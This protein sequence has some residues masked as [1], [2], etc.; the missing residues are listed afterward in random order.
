M[1]IL[2]ATAFATRMQS[3]EKVTVLGE[4]PIRVR[5]SPMVIAG[6]GLFMQGPEDDQDDGAK[7]AELAQ[8][9]RDATRDFDEPLPQ[10]M[11]GG[12]FNKG[13]FLYTFNRAIDP[14][15][16]SGAFYPLRKIVEQMAI[17]LIFPLTILGIVSGALRGNPDRELVDGAKRLLVVMGLLWTYPLWDILVF[18]GIAGPVSLQLGS[19]V[20]RDVFLMR[21]AARRGIGRNPQAT[22]ESNRDTVRMFL[23]GRSIA[24]DSTVRASTSITGGV[25]DSV[26]QTMWESLVDFHQ[27]D[28]GCATRLGG[29]GLGGNPV[30]SS[31]AAPADTGRKPLG[32]ESYLRVQSSTSLLQPEFRVKLVEMQRILLSRGIR[33]RVVET[34]RPQKRQEWL[35]AEGKSKTLRSYHATGYAADM[36]LNNTYALK[37][38]HYYAEMKDVATSLNLKT[39]WAWDAGHVEMPGKPRGARPNQVLASQ[40]RPGTVVTTA[41]GTPLAVID[42]TAS[43]AE[44]PQSVEE[45]GLYRCIGD[46]IP[47]VDQL[48]H[49]NSWL[50]MANGQLQTQ[51]QLVTRIKSTW[52]GIMT[53]LSAV[54]SWVQAGVS[55]VATAGAWGL[56]FLKAF[57]TRDWSTI[58]AMMAD[59]LIGALLQIVNVVMAA[60]FWL[61]WFRVILMRAFSL[62][63][64]PF[65]IVLGLKDGGTIPGG[66]KRWFVEHAK[67]CMQPIGLSLA[68]FMFF[69]LSTMIM[70]NPLSMVS[71]TTARA[72]SSRPSYPFALASFSS[73][74]S[75]GL[76]ASVAGPTIARENFS[77]IADTT[78]TRRDTVITLPTAHNPYNILYVDSTSFDRQQMDLM[79]EIPLEETGVATIPVPVR[80]ALLAILVMLMLSADK[81]SNALGGEVASLGKVV[82]GIVTEKSAQWAWKATKIG[83]KVAAAVASGGTSLVKDGVEMGLKAAAKNAIKTAG[84]AAIKGAKD[85]LAGGNIASLGQKKPGRLDGLVQSALGV[86]GIGAG[87]SVAMSREDATM[88]GLVAPRDS[89]APT[90]ARDAM[91]A[92]DAASSQMNLPGLDGS[93]SAQS[94]HPELGETA[95]TRETTGAY[96]QSAAFLEGMSPAVEPTWTTPSMQRGSLPPAQEPLAGVAALMISEMGRQTQPLAGPQAAMREVMIR[97]DAQQL[98]LN[99]VRALPASE[100]IN[101]LIKISRTRPELRVFLPST[102]AKEEMR[103]TIDWDG[104][105]GAGSNVMEIMSANPQVL[106][107]TRMA[108]EGQ[109]LMEIVSLRPDVQQHLFAVAQQEGDGRPVPLRSVNGAMVVD[110]MHPSNLDLSNILG[111]MVLV[112]GQEWLKS[113]Q[114]RQKAVM[115]AGVTGDS[116]IG[117]IVLNI[118]GRLLA[119]PMQGGS[120]E[121]L[122]TISLQVLR[123]T[124]FR[125]A[126]VEQRQALGLRLTDNSLEAERAAMTDLR[127]DASVSWM[128]QAALPRSAERL[129]GKDIDEQVWKDVMSDIQAETT[130]RLR[131]VG[132]GMSLGLNA[133]E[134][135]ESGGARE[136]YTAETGSLLQQLQVMAPDLSQAT[137]VALASEVITQAAAQGVR[138]EHLFTAAPNAATEALYS[139]AG[140][141][142]V[143]RARLDQV[144]AHVGGEAHVLALLEGQVAGTDLLAEPSLQVRHGS[145]L[146]VALQQSGG[147]IAD[148][149]AVLKA[150]PSAVILTAALPETQRNLLG[151][152]DN[153]PRETESPGQYFTR[154]LGLEQAAAIDPAA[155]TTALESVLSLTANDKDSL[156]LLVSQGAFLPALGS[157]LAEARLRLGPNAT[158]TEVVAAAF[159]LI[160]KTEDTAT[161]VSIDSVLLQMSSPKSVPLETQE[162]VPALTTANSADVAALFAAPLVSGG[163]ISLVDPMS[164]TERTS[165]AELTQKKEMRQ[166]TQEAVEAQFEMTLKES[167]SGAGHPQTV[168]PN[169]SNGR[170]NEIS[171]E[172]ENLSMPTEVSREDRVAGMEG[173]FNS[174]ASELRAEGRVTQE[175]TLALV[176]QEDK[177]RVD[178]GE[179]VS[180][181]RGDNTQQQVTQVN[182]E[183]IG[184]PVSS[185]G[186]ASS[187]AVPVSSNLEAL[188]AGPSGAQNKRVISESIQEEKEAAIGVQSEGSLEAAVESIVSA[189]K[190]REETT[191]GVSTQEEKKN[192]R[193]FSVEK[194]TQK[195]SSPIPV[196]LG[197][198]AATNQLA[199]EKPDADKN[200]NQTPDAS[201][202]NRVENLG[203]LDAATVGTA[204]LETM[205]PSQKSQVDPFVT[206]GI[207]AKEANSASAS[208]GLTPA[209]KEEERASTAQAALPEASIPHAST[210][211]PGTLVIKEQEA[212]HVNQPLKTEVVAQQV[213]QPVVP[214]VKEQEAATVNQALKTEVVTPEVPTPQPVVPVVK[215]QEAAPV[216]Q[217]LKAEGATPQVSTPQ[218]VVP[219]VPVVKE[220]EAATVNQALKTKVVT[221][222]V[223]TPQP[224]VKEQEAAP[225]NQALKTE[226]AT[227]RVS[228]PQPVTPAVKEQDAA[229]VN[230]PLKTEVVTPQVAPPQPV[231]SVVK[232]QEAAPV[233]RD[234]GANIAVTPVP[235][236]QPVAPVIQ[237]QESE[238]AK[239]GNVRATP[240]PVTQTADQVLTEKET[241]PVS[242]GNVV[243]STATA[244][245]LPLPAA[246]VL[247]EQEEAGRGSSGKKKLE[248]PA[249]EASSK[250]AAPS[251][252]D[253]LPAPDTFTSQQESGMVKEDKGE[254][255]GFGPSSLVFEGYE[256]R[257]ESFSE[258]IRISGA[259][260]IRGSSI[261]VPNYTEGASSWVEVKFND[262]TSPSAVI[263]SVETA[264]VS[265]GVHEV[266]VIC[267]FLTGLGQPIVYRTLTVKLTINAVVDNEPARTRAYD[268][269]SAVVQNIP[270]G[271]KARGVA[272]HL[273]SNPGAIT[274][275]SSEYLNIL[276]PFSRGMLPH[277]APFLAKSARLRSWV[278]VMA[279]PEA[280]RLLEDADAIFEWSKTR[281]R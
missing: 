37:D 115:A 10:T 200:T 228:T 230:Q 154:A 45:A 73:A 187:E 98:T 168:S 171:R 65:V 104:V 149:D 38:M 279:G 203:Q 205:S 100:Q 237:K 139:D 146:A 42:P 210:A 133:K 202:F 240:V 193:T 265:A 28:V 140:K 130:S 5:S 184:V 68:M 238:P 255:I 276:G 272:E 194:E 25:P 17:W 59:A 142:M 214:V 225:V 91:N 277:L 27:S 180:Q 86:A 192:P 125:Q 270:K 105:L 40:R 138:P 178:T 12:P 232:E 190:K 261:N 22:P 241:A 51:G 66:A 260:A 189:R 126:T 183:N 34:Y 222:E 176:S 16:V 62:T 157:P 207:G 268:L 234:P 253:L 188:F 54:A 53:K 3:A 82:G 170:R 90:E 88:E 257:N 206:Q 262:P 117:R 231:A 81:I 43:T 26:K 275:I 191:D 48:A 219:V 239:T 215:E 195:E 14:V 185:Q 266:E 24:M 169:V 201:L 79:N 87:S 281:W 49:T 165:M 136:T 77:P 186:V 224:V 274:Q 64:A 174:A 67:Y 63:F 108:I 13:T 198:V 161:P 83:V 254:N 44:N 80:L 46:E 69:V 263:V 78:G 9:G 2:I 101:I 94:S 147:S 155:A 235:A 264:G 166:G 112:D 116:L 220:Q 92:Y 167:V 181:M 227:P 143:A 134:W 99:V 120:H 19:P 258:R 163:T 113:H 213:S 118:D 197:S 223:S 128:Q 212:P 247:S 60:I 135:L 148:M 39:L 249:P 72:E 172:Q 211:Q 280:V 151:G 158:D 150:L 75:S 145:P 123:R 252:D 93:P 278:G 20:M 35:K 107:G 6:Q 248:G 244:I 30:T 209:V 160:S 152:L 95:D 119:A 164:S 250:K 85:R 141:E 217:A 4:G 103:I 58:G 137:H 243:D 124:W 61:L 233:S 144:L 208:Q 236:A 182:K 229:P 84:N 199:V 47:G 221:P 246:T 131:L 162:R 23:Y 196:N 97:P 175:N 50:G 96:A 179:S 216:N 71:G 41:G 256:G 55:R 102:G 218:L 18:R 31:N 32:T 33:S 29:D 111:Q 21:E 226:V 269:A 159:T 156:K 127:I 173:L 57:L 110:L 245:S 177:Q 70:S 153:G 76:F 251:S 15:L 74:T 132:G 242:Q 114:V 204:V 121:T 271:D 106:V 52:K 8:L 36:I 7:L 122:G 89:M 11:T 267:E 273:M 56:K 1:P 129:L 109:R 259:S